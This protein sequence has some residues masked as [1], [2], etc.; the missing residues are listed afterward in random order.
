METKDRIKG[1]IDELGSKAHQAGMAATERAKEGVDK[2]AGLA[3]RLG[4]KAHDAAAA[5]GEYAREAGQ[6]VDRMADSVVHA[7]HAVVDWT[8]D[9]VQHPGDKLVAGR[10]QMAG[11]VRRYPIACVLAAVGVGFMLSR[12]TRI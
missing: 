1:A 6:T 7:K 9:A 5:V 2:A 4:E 11:F 10:D 3:E 8:A 12:L